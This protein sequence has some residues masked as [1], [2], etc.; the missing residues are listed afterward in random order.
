MDFY[1][2]N[3]HAKELI[4]GKAGEIWFCQDCEL[5]ETCKKQY[6]KIHPIS[7]YVYRYLVDMENGC[8]IYPN[9][10]SWEY[11]PE[12]FVRLL[13]SATAKLH[14]LQSEKA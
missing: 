6:G 12:W 4:T 7:L 5:Y 2:Q 10:K 9:G 3:P 14:E 13:N 11:E 8:K 1:Q